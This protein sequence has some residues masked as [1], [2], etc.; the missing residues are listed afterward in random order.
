MDVHAKARRRLPFILHLA[1][2]NFIA[3]FSPQLRSFFLVL[4]ALG[5]LTRVL[6]FTQSV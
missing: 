5:S 4:L 6:C 1:G 3:R 2:G